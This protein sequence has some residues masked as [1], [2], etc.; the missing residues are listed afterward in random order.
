MKLTRI[1]EIF[2][3]SKIQAQEYVLRTTGGG[4]QKI[5]LNNSLVSGKGKILIFTVIGINKFYKCEEWRITPELSTLELEAIAWTI[6][7][8]LEESK[9]A[10]LPMEEN[11]KKQS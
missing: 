5:K 3:Q 4:R 11:R 7:S 8:S 6:D 2:E 10:V 1:G 9:T